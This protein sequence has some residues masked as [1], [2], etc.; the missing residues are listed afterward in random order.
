[1]ASTLTCTFDGACEP[2]NPGGAMGLGWTVDGAGKHKFVTSSAENTNNI[3]EYMALEA[4]L[5]QLLAADGSEEVQISGDSQLVIEQLHGT[6]AVHSQRVYPHF[7]RVADKLAELRTR[8]RRVSVSWHPREHNE[9]ADRESKFALTENGIQPAIRKPSKGF[10]NFGAIGKRCER[11]AV[12]VGRCLAFLGYRDSAGLPTDKALVDHPIADL[13]FDGFGIRTDW[14]IE[15]GA[16]IVAAAPPEAF[17]AKPRHREKKE[18]MVEVEGDTYP[19]REALKALGG[20]WRPRKRCW[21]VPASRVEE[22]RK[23]VA[24]CT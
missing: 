14:D 21:T 18:R 20:K 8:G 7:R 4:L 5:D 22:A 16:A 6:Y 17:A 12:M 1:M 23:A 2:Y 13:R 11:S 24:S 10:G 3:A 9:Q 15:K 19:A